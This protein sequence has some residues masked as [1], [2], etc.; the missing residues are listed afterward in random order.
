MARPTCS[1]CNGKGQGAC[2][3]PY[4]NNG[5]DENIKATCTICNG[6]KIKTCPTCGG[7]GTT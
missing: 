5:W 7:K 1:G 2:N 3:N 6:T 4:C